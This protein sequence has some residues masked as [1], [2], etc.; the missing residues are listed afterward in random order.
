M[1][2]PRGP[3]KRELTVEGCQSSQAQ[4]HERRRHPPTNC[5][6]FTHLVTNYS[7]Q[8]GG[9]TTP[10][11][12]GPRDGAPSRPTR[13]AALAAAKPIVLRDF[14]IETAEAA[15]TLR[16]INPPYMFKRVSI[17]CW[18][19]V[20]LLATS[21]FAQDEFKKP[22]IGFLPGVVDPFYQVMEIG[23]K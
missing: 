11:P 17:S 10:F 5:S 2:S 19:L 12:L 9:H 7:P 4:T 22:K 3:N 21:L 18:S 23:V 20:A 13:C 14:Q 6:S 16:V 8:A 1:C 15:V